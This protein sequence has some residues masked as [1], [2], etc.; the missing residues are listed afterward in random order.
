MTIP[1]ADK[2]SE[3][4]DQSYITDGKLKWNNHSGKYFDTL[5]VSYKAKQEITI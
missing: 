1:N 2:D 5:T 3:K 4:L